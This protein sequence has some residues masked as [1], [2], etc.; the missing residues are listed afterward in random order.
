MLTYRTGA[1]GSTRA[2]A[3][4]ADHLLEQT[5]PRSARD[6]AQYY[7]RGLDPDRHQGT[8]PEPRRDMDPRVAAVLALDPHRTPTRDEI[9][10]LL[11]GRRADGSE[12]PGRERIISFIDLCFSA[13]KSVALAWA[14]APTEAERNAV[15]QAHRDAVE[16]AMQYIATELGRARKGAGGRDGADVGHIGWVAF[17]HYASRPT[18]EI[19]RRRADG[20]LETE[21]ITLKVAGDP[22]LHTHVAVPNV[23]LTETGRVGSLDLQRLQ[24]R[25]HEFGAYYQAHLAQNLRR[26]GA[27]IVLDPRTGAGRLRQIPDHVR[28]AFSKRT[29]D[30]LEDARTYA[31]KIGQEWDGLSPDEQIALLKSGAFASRRA[32]ADDCSD[33]DAWREQA[34][35]LGW[36]HTSI[37]QRRTPPVE[38]TQDERTACA[39]HTALPLL[40]AELGRRSVLNGSD[41]RVAATRGL[42]ES[43]LEGP[44][45]I[46]RVTRAFRERGVRQS[47]RT[48]ALLWGH[49]SVRGNIKVSTELHVEQEREL[50]RLAATAAQDRSASLSPESIAHSVAR[51][52]LDFSTDHGA[53]QRQIIDRL[54][55]GG[56]LSVAIGV[57]GAGKTALLRPLV[58]AWRERGSAVH[59]IALAWRQSDDLAAAGIDRGRLAAL[60]VFLNRVTRGTVPLDGNSVVV[61]DELGLIGAAQFLQLLRLQQRHGFQIVAVG[62]PKQAQ[63]IEAGPVIELL[64]QALGKDAIPEILTTLRQQN[65]RERQTA[66]LFR[67]GRAAEALA[68][69]R[70]DGTAEIIAGGYRQTIERA[71][72]LWQE[73]RQANADDRS[74]TL[75]VSAPTNADARAISA[76]IRQRRHAA[77]EVEPDQVVLRAVDQ[78]GVMYDLPLARGDRVR[79]FTRT[80]ASFTD[81][82]KGNIGNNGSVL[83]VTDIGSAGLKLRNAHGNEGLVKWDTLRDPVTGRFRLSYGDVL[84]IDATQGLTST[85]HLNV[86]PAGTQAV[87]GFKAYVAESRHRVATWL[88]TSDGA[89][90]QGIANRRPLG[91]PRPIRSQDVWEN[92]AR[93]LSRQR[94]KASALAFLARAREIH[95]GAA[96]GFQNGLHPSEMRKA[97]E[98]EPT[99]LH[100]TFARRRQTERVERA[101]HHLEQ[102]MHDRGAM[103]DR[104]ADIGPALR[105][106]VHDGVR[107]VT[108]AVRRVAARLAAA[109]PGKTQS[110]ATNHQQHRRGPRR[111]Q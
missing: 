33:F 75:T 106:A 39:Y 32:K 70:Q 49:D 99:T 66:L 5:L 54:G 90:R 42:I 30:A 45:D 19:A 17:D 76:A 73:R 38:L 10:N 71:A 110:D 62:D 57:A 69:K 96:R 97:E 107:Q 47:S 102:A 27:E 101:G 58:D 51:S 6:L 95:R 92:M 56:R 40:E 85:E 77:G 48:T 2:A 60:S 98:Q 80:Y 78:I 55:M 31:M 104:L 34:K 52:G 37:F 26:L 46:N 81:G 28:D 18:V 36:H 20:E 105:S 4:M 68:M 16:H 24:G 72:D 109:W 50:I 103:I 93:N 29:R 65:E 12:L 87:L 61:V 89:E 64:R 13:D 22:N 23:V 86:M 11:V 67:E 3:T 1:A 63:A 43:G 59:G 25:V 15:A 79:L 9:A 94:E 83:D 108:P 53:T 74:Y 35:G 14:F 21:L 84:S 8:V 100:R 41:A 88:L 82:R 7:Q 44:D 111:S 91:D